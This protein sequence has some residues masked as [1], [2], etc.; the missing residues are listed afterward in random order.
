VLDF[1]D[2]TPELGAS[3]SRGSKNVIR[4]HIFSLQKLEPQFVLLGGIKQP[5]DPFGHEGNIH[6]P[7]VD[8]T[9][10]SLVLWP[11]HS[12]PIHPVKLP[13]IT[14]TFP[15]KSCQVFVKTYMRTL[16]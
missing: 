13:L 2:T 11:A 12:W 16:C 1:V 14:Y 8:N 3:L 5:P 4:I 6:I 15:K 10:T 9:Q 7:R